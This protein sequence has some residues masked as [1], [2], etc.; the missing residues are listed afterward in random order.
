[1]GYSQP[2]YVS[3]DGLTPLQR[4]LVAGLRGEYHHAA[5]T[6]GNSILY[7]IY[8]YTG[9][10]LFFLFIAYVLYLVANLPRSSTFSA[11]R[12]ATRASPKRGYR[13]SPKR[14]T[15]RSLKRG[16]KHGRKM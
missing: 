16:Y 3:P 11:Y 2:V 4:H 5:N 12:S 1:M 15:R 9:R 14:S 13:R 7:T 6:G 8:L 10:P